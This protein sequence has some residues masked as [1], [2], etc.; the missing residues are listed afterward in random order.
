MYQRKIR[1][2]MERA[3]KRKRIKLVRVPGIKEPQPVLTVW[4]GRFEGWFREQMRQ[5]V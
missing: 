5:D 2:Y 4:N 1:R 3:N